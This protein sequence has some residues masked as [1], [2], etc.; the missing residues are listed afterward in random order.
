MLRLL[1]LVGIA[2]AARQAAGAHGY[3]DVSGHSIYEVARAAYCRPD[4]LN[5]TAWT[6]EGAGCVPCLMTNQT[7]LT[8]HD[9]ERPIQGAETSWYDI[10]GARTA[11]FVAA[12]RSDLDNVTRI[13]LSFRG[14]ELSAGMANVLTDL[15]FTPRNVT[16][17]LPGCD[18]CFVHHAIWDAWLNVRLTLTLTLTLTLA[19]TVYHAIWDACPN[20]LNPSALRRATLTAG[21]HRHPNPNAIRPLML[22]L[23]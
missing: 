21:V 3:D 15:F 8:A 23:A 11:F 5:L 19:L 4:T 10:H 17:I 22:T 20:A 13:F 1:P 16:R 7:V 2:A 6:V 9:P 18:D 14:T 12:L